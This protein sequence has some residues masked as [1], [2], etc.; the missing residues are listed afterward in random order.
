MLKWI[1]Q[2]C[3][4]QKQLRLYLSFPELDATGYMEK[5]RKANVHLLG[6]K[7]PNRKEWVKET[8]ERW[9]EK[10]KGRS[11]GVNNAV[12]EEFRSAQWWR[13]IT[14]TWAHWQR[15]EQRWKLQNWTVISHYVLW[16]RTL[17]G[18]DPFYHK[19]NFASS[20]WGQYC[21]TLEIYNPN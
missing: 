17:K 9:E 8:F 12:I 13:W 1:V 3:Q 11:C 18:M 20:Y 21:F 15:I 19:K 4:F 10:G 6:R 14:G 2:S 16:T 5:S 7:K